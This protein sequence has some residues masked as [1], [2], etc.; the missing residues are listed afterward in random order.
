M[1]AVKC[2][3]WD[4]DDTVWRGVAIESRDQSAPPVDPAVLH[5]VDVLEQRGIISSV[6][7]RT[8]SSMLSL[9]QAHPQLGDRFVAPRLSW[10]YKSAAIKSIADELGI[11]TN[12]IAFVD[13]SAFER[14][15][16]T[17][18]VPGVR[19]FSPDEFL[20]RLDT[21]DFKPEVVTS[22]ARQRPR[23]YR[24]ETQRRAAELD[25]TGG[26]EAFLRGSDIRVDL[27]DAQESDIDRLVELV[28][29]THRFNTTGEEWPRDQVRHAVL[30]DPWFVP[31]ARMSDRFG[32][33]GLIGAAF[34]DRSDAAVWRLRMFTVSC[35]AAGRDVPGAFL[36]RLLAAART[37][38]AGQLTCDI[39]PSSANLELRVLLRG[40]GFVAAAEPQ[41]GELVT[42]ARDTSA[43]ELRTPSWLSITEEF[44]IG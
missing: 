23:R 12:A 36:D 18:N 2:V 34:V 15:E 3:V 5:A 19:A 40:A 17:A 10:G 30:E 43:G 39:R 31:V 4:L 8:D 28:A 13:D 11:A 6:A 20:A 22:D 16:V 32:D 44:R 26:T 27:R 7:S 21:P 33:Y 41:A 37:A 42:L 25:F 14:A 29:R 24:E 1:T 35:R 38:G 9:L